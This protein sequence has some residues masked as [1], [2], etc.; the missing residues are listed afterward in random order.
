[1]SFFNDF[2]VITDKIQINGESM[3]L[4]SEPVTIEFNNISDGGRLADV[5]DYEGDL[6]GVKV[7]IKLK[8]TILNKEH[9]DKV[10]SATQGAYLN[11]KGFFMEIKVPTYT[12]LGIQTYKGYFMSSHTPG[13]TRTTEDKYYATGDSRY[14]YGGSLYDELHEDVE[15]SFVQQ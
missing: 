5:V 15:F 8:Y 9:Y 4:T 3:P 2:T 7:N 11:D 13:C 1:M 10:F 12:P 14:D 6:K